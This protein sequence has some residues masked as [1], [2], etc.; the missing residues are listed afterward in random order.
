MKL[1]KKII[2]LLFF[3]KLIGV[4][5]V[6]GLFL[7]GYFG[8]F[9]LINNEEEVR[10]ITEKINKGTLI[11]SL[12]GNGQVSA[13]DQIDI[14]F[15][16]LGEIIYIGVVNG[17]EVKKGTLLAQLDT[18]DAQ[19]EIRDAEVNLES[20]QLN[21]DRILTPVSDLDLMQAENNLSQAK[22]YKVSVEN[23]L[24]EI[25]EEAINSVSNTFLDFPSVVIGLQNILFSDDL[26]G[27]GQWNI[28]Y[29]GD[30][31]NFY[32]E[33]S[34]GMKDATYDSYMK[35]E[36]IYDINFENFK[37]VN[38]NS[39][40][41]EI[42]ALVLE[43]YNTAKSLSDAIKDSNNLIQLYQ[44]EY[45]ERNLTPKQLS[46]SH[47][48]SLSSYTGTVNNILSELLS[49]KNSIKNKKEDIINAERDI[50]EKTKIYEELVNGADEYDIRSQELIVKQRENALI[51]AQE[52]LYDYYIYAPFDGVIAKTEINKGEFVNSNLTA[53]ILITDQ[54][55]AEIVLNEIEIADVEI[56]QKVNLKLDAVEDYVAEG[57]VIEIDT[58]G[59]VSSGVVDYGVRIGFESSN[60][61]IKPGMS[62]NAEIIIEEK[63]DVLIVSNSAISYVRNKAFVQILEN[64]Q[65]KKLPVEVG[66]ITDLKTEIISGLNGG[67]EIVIG[68]DLSTE[69]VNPEN[70]PE[71]SQRGTG[72]MQMMKAI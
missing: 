14:K 1:I 39:D 13:S 53:F 56:G 17:Q 33:N 19:K 55:T 41:E 36:K 28:S 70:K 9:N 60:E 48:N 57:T 32:N 40:P 54:K 5:F 45:A 47:L 23:A 18:N 59:T 8:Y 34:D 6:G 51:D 12:S 49:L 35:A 7:M 67:T 25:Y 66:M 22:E 20:A 11:S 61:K 46:S 15:K 65:L 50:Q 10:Y 68:E 62:V 63:E 27:S 26:S 43:T 44:D 29:Y 38:R 3:N 4:A 71:A 16:T 30:S 2:S 52:N 37:I 72:S 64:G 69:P 31:I 42:E 58:I 24:D 21:L